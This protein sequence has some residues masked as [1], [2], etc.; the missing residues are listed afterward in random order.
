MGER[1]KDGRVRRKIDVKEEEERN[2]VKEGERGE[3]YNS[4]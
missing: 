4:N 2:M 3:R 1:G